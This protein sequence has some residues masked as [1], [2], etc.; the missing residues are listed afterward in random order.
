[1]G[2]VYDKPSIFKLI[3]WWET[4]WYDQFGDQS[5][6]KSNAE[7]TTTGE[8]TQTPQAAANAR[9]FAGTAD[10]TKAFEEDSDAPVTGGP[11]TGE[12]ITSLKNAIK[13][14][15]DKANLNYDRYLRALAELENFKKRVARERL[16]QMRYASEDMLREVLPV[17]DNL[18]RTLTFSQECHDV[19]KILEGVELIQRQF[20][21]ALAKTGVTAID[22]APCVF[23]PAI[24][25]ALQRVEDT[26]VPDDTVI[27]ILQKGYSLNGKVVRPAMVKVAKHA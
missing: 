14:L 22:Q 9:N 19:S 12:E 10:P 21:Q 3:G 24:H 26:S 27:A 20:Q 13:E 1:M 8:A 15:D 6:K 17:L 23:D 7:G 11:A 25:Q 2:L 16:E 4:M 5:A 18:E